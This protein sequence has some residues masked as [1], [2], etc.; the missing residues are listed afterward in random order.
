MIPGHFMILP[1]FPSLPNGK[2]DSKSLASLRPHAPKIPEF[3]HHQMNETEV[4]LSAIWNE[5]LD[6][7]SFTL[8]D[9]FFEA[10]GHS[11]LLVRMKELIAE[12]LNAEVSIVDLFHYPSISSLAAFLRKDKPENPISDIAKRV[13]MR[14]RNIKQQIIKR[15]F[16]DKNQF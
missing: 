3:I 13:A 6:H 14:N 1:K 4:S 9:N 16:P 15:I 8:K 11:L 7:D 2:L 10:G 12:K 5:I